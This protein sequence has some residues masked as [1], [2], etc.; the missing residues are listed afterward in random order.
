MMAG[1]TVQVIHHDPA[2]ETNAQRSNLLMASFW[3][4]Y[5]YNPSSDWY[6]LAEDYKIVVPSNLRQLLQLLNSSSDVYTGRCVISQRS[7]RFGQLTFVMGGAGILMSRTLQAKLVP[8]I[9]SCRQDLAKF[10]H[11]DT[12][13]AACLKRN[14]LIPENMC[15][16]GSL[17]YK[18]TSAS[19]WFE[20]TKNR[21]AMVTT[22]HEKNATRIALLNGAVHELEQRRTPITW[23]SLLPYLL[24]QTFHT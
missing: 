20:A 3:A 17:P 18:F 12:R 16:L 21:H 23:G 7:E 6:L 11:G 2:Y 22:M 15:V 19:P 5:Q 14:N 13:I 4:I 24:N 8:H 1:R 9:P 10:Q